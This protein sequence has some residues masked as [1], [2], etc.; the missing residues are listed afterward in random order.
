M[1]GLIPWGI[2][3][4]SKSTA[5][6]GGTDYQLISTTVLGSTS[7]NVTF[8][9]TGLGSTYKHLQIRYTGRADYTNTQSVNLRLN[10]DSGS[11]YAIHSLGGGGS[12]TFT[13]T[14]ASQT[15]MI[16]F[17]GGL[18]GT[19]QGSNIF[20]SGVLDFLDPFS[21]S[22]YKTIRSLNG[23][24]GNVTNNIRLNSGLWMNTNAVTSI[25]LS[26]QNGNFI[27]GSRFSLY[28]LVG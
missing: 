7:P 26:T 8:S 17:L 20:E 19:N 2:W 11:N 4:A 3:A 22:K 13:D 18:P 16:G 5:A 21:T 15:Q 12:S 23:T 27:A 24:S 6:A 10:G 25:V 1:P 28:G 14:S 9:V